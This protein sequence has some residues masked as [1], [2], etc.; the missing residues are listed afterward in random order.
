MGAK[1]ILTGPASTMPYTTPLNLACLTQARLVK[2]V[3]GD[4]WS[5]VLQQRTPSGLDG[6][7]NLAAGQETVSC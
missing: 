6:C 2:A 7:V 3:P 4:M 1:C 5:A